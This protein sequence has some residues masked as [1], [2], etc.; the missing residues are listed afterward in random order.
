[1]TTV[2]VVVVIAR[3]PAAAR[4][5]RLAFALALR[6]RIGAEPMGTTATIVAVA[7][8]ATMAASVTAVRIAVRTT[9][10]R[11][12]IG[13]WAPA[14]RTASPGPAAPGGP[15]ILGFRNTQRASPDD[16]A[17]HRGDGLPRFLLGRHF[18]EGEAARSLRFP[19]EWYVNALDGASLGEG[20]ADGSFIGVVWKVPDVQSLAHAKWRCGPDPTWP[21]RV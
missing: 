20:G 21:R 9:S 19:I 16:G 18:D 10:A 1:M 15:T 11:P 6:L 8:S 13:S 2:E 7:R 5:A 14:P 12:P 3:T 4:L 17:V